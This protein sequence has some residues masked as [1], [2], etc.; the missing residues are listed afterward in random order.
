MSLNRLVRQLQN[1]GDEVRQIIDDCELTVEIDNIEDDPT[2]RTLQG[3][4]DICSTMARLDE[5]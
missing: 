4:L 1:I 5:L 3:M 2:R